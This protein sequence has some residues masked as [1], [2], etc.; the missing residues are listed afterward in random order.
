MNERLKQDIFPYIDELTD[1]QLMELA[2]KNKVYIDPGKIRLLT[3]LG[4]NGKFL[5]YSNRQRLLETKRIQYQRKLEKHKGLS[6]DGECIKDIEAELNNYNSKSCYLI[7]FLK[8]VT[9]KNATNDKLFVK[10][11]NLI[12]RK[13]KWYTY[14]NTQRSEERLVANIKKIFGDDIVLMMGDWSI[15]KQF[16]NY[17]STPMISLKKMLKH[18]FDIIN[19]DEYNTSKINYKTHEENDNLYLH[20]TKRTKEQYKEHHELKLKTKRDKINSKHN[21]LHKRNNGRKKYKHNK[22][23]QKLLCEPILN[24]AEPVTKLPVEGLPEIVNEVK[25]YYKLHSV[26]TYKMENNRLGCINRDKNAVFNMK[27]IVTQW[28]ENKTRPAALLRGKVKRTNPRNIN[29]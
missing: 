9:I 25:G 26:L 5:T 23:K 3:M 21:N 6:I 27:S 10:Y 20:I 17:I 11:E 29:L 16:R 14:I 1:L 15:S 22:T 2:T 7:T 24:T 13:L 12:F 19:I 28:L 8:Y 18:Y 4:D